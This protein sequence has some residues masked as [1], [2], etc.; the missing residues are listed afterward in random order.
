MELRHIRYFIAVAE[1]CHFGKAAERLHMA[2]SPLSQQIKQL[3]SELGVILLTRSTRK[4]ELTAAGD[5]Y[6][7]RARAILHAVESARDEA[8]RVA[9]GTLGSVRIGFTGSATY[10]LLPALARALRADFP[11]LELGLQ[12]EMLTADQVDALNAGTLDLALLRPPVRDPSLEVTVLRR[13]PLIAVLPAAHPLANGTEVR[14]TDLRDEPFITY[15]SN[16]RSVVYGAMTDACLSAGFRPSVVQE[17]AE[18]ATLISFVAAGIGVSLAPA[19]VQ[20]LQIT[21]ATTRPLAGPAR[22]VELAL[23]TRSDNDKPHVARVLAH[24]CALFGIRRTRDCR[25]NDASIAG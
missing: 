25:T 20:H 15:P 18:T 5:R 17:V 10:E 7:E 19:S 1:E 2:Q 3:E 14:L 13:E 16:H 12:G 9:M 21:G 22:E 4:V 6:L 24:T 23:A 11:D 8:Q